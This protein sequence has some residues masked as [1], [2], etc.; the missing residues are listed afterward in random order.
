MYVSFLSDVPSI[1][2]QFHEKK[3][4][5]FDNTCVRGMGMGE[6]IHKRVVGTSGN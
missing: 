4:W 1:F 3:G 6:H 2:K 5:E